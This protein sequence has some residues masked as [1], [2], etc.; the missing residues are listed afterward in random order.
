MWIWCT[1]EMAFVVKY[2]LGERIPAKNTALARDTIFGLFTFVFLVLVSVD[3]TN[4][5]GPDNGARLPPHL[6]SLLA[7][8]KAASRKSIINQLQAR[9]K[10]SEKPPPF[11]DMI[12]DLRHTPNALF[13]GSL[14]KAR[15]AVDAESL[16]LVDEAHRQYVTEMEGKYGHLECTRV[17]R[18]F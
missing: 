8:M 9:T 15:R 5:A 11:K 12:R 10:D 17:A 18:E 6:G 16:R 3:G 13:P 2:H 7:K 14:R 4:T 1:S